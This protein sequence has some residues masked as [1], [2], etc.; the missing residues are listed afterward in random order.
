MKQISKDLVHEIILK[1]D[2]KEPYDFQTDIIVGE[3][4]QKIY[5]NI[6]LDNPLLIAV[7]PAGG[8]TFMAGLICYFYCL[9]N[10]KNRIL[11]VAEGKKFLKGQFYSDLK[12]YLVDSHL[13]LESDIEIIENKK[14]FINSHAKI[15]VI[16]PQTIKTLINDEKFSFVKQKLN[17][18]LLVFDEA[19]NWYETKN[20]D[21]QIQRL[22]KKLK[23]DNEILLT[24]SPSSFNGRGFPSYYV[25]D[26]DLPANRKSKMLFEL[27]KTKTNIKKSDFK[28]HELDIDYIWGKTE[29]LNV[30]HDM[31]DRFIDI[32]INKLKSPYKNDPISFYRSLDGRFLEKIVKNSTR[33][34]RK[35]FVKEYLEKT[36]IFCHNIELAIY[37]HNILK[38]MLDIP[39][40]ISHSNP[41][42]EVGYDKNS[43]K[44]IDF[45]K[46]G[47]KQAILIVVERAR[48][49]FNDTSIVNVIDLTCSGNPEPI[50][51]IMDRGKRPFD[52]ENKKIKTYIK[53]VPEGEESYAGFAMEFAIN[54]GRREIFTTYNKKNFN[55]TGI[56]CVDDKD[57]GKNQDTH[58]GIDS[59]KAQLEKEIN[60]LKNKNKKLKNIIKKNKLKESS[61]ESNIKTKI[62]KKIPQVWKLDSKYTVLNRVEHFD[63]NLWSSVKY[64]IMTP[65][66]FK[67]NMQG[68][69]KWKAKLFARGMGF[70]EGTKEYM[71]Y[72]NN[73]KN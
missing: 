61:D 7:T 20:G 25:S 32:M 37:I 62:I 21:G 64:V 58:R 48:E 68:K 50:K 30:V 47:N 19:Q 57:G 56:V 22:R 13:M 15:V 17:F 18:N 53:V 41:K 23:H 43:D 69:T 10:H 44:L 36:V 49:A 9:K 3:Y 45:K 42:Y 38:S 27:V 33:D 34:L 63:D 65:G 52:S 51:Q 54:L 16:N 67:S 14:E 35:I 55:N 1:I 60:T 24:G 28:N 5:N 73:F 8:K 72:V 40:F 59:I 6:L 12:E 39:L 31:I 11:I 29:A 71:D 70:A 26:E 66:E 4:T 2:N 46:M